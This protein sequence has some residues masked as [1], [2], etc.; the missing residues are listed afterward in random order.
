MKRSIRE[1]LPRMFGKR[2]RAGS[3]SAFAAVMVIAI[4]VIANMVAGALPSAITQLDLTSQA[5]YSLSDQTKRIAA[6]LDKDVALYLLATTGNEDDTISRLLDRYAGLSDHISV[7]YVDPAV[8]PTFLE[9][10]DLSLSQLYANSVLVEC[11]ERYRL[12]SYSDIYVTSYDMNYSTYNYT[13][14]TEFDGENALTNAIHYVSS[15][16]LP[17]VYVLTGHGETELSE[18]MLEMLAQDNMETESLSLLS[19]DS[20]PEDA[21][22][23]IVSAPTGDVS[24]D[25]ADMLKAYLENGGCMALV[26][27]YMDAGE[28]SNLLSVTSAMGLTVERGLILEGDGRMHVNRYPYYLLPDIQ[29]HEITDPLMEGGYYILTPL[30]QPIVETADSSSEVTFLLN[31]SDSAYAK[32]D[33]LNAT[34]TDRE[35]GDAEGSFHVA[36]AA[37]QGEGKL[38]WFSSALLLDESVDRM[39]SGA[40][41]NL[42]LNALNWMCEQ[43]E[44][45]S[46][47][48]KSMDSGTLTL[49]SSESTMW[50]IV[51]V[52][53][54]PAAFVAVGVGICIRRKRR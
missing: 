50:S 16:N 20:V 13:T 15:D 9:N 19:L 6:S 48:A 36:A 38:C 46:I 28:M 43:E 53:L 3:Y 14:T 7:T 23:V 34:T 12:V 5:I 33:G 40:N 45:I 11:G 41:S 24:E 21:S 10:Y 27:D 17:K 52:G 37:Q 51:M 54:I 8:R 35:E 26:T 22:A 31:T 47:R 49:T 30:A 32:L 44:S 1:S 29:S 39:V 42:F 4:A 2:F 25:E 18:S